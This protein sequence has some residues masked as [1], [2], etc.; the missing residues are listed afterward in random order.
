M[1]DV[2][3]MLQRLG[4]VEPILDAD[5][6]LQRAERRARRLSRTRMQRRLTAVGVAG[7]LLVG[8]VVVAARTGNASRVGPTT[9]LTNPPKTSIGVAPSKYVLRG[10]RTSDFLCPEHISGATATGQPVVGATALRVCV[11]GGTPVTVRAGQP[12]FEPL[13]AA[14][15]RPDTK[16]SHGCPLYADVPQILVAQTPVGDFRVS[17][18]V[19]GCGHYQAEV[20]NAVSAARGVLMMTPEQQ[21][22][23]TPSCPEDG[24]MLTPAQ[25]AMFATW[26]REYDPAAVAYATRDAGDASDLAIVTTMDF[27][28]ACRAATSALAAAEQASPTQRTAT[29]DGLMQPTLAALVQHAWPPKPAGS[30]LFN[31]LASLMRHGD[32]AR[33]SANLRVCAQVVPSP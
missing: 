13:L 24:P 28:A 2:R 9:S 25:K 5:E 22:Q 30:R 18:P 14:L 17:M 33:A 3:E 7:V 8:G 19:D 27:R 4:E 26:R 21:A 29:V 31:N 12:I 32:F 10:A 6:V 20:R 16:V 23:C 1:N 11:T 15:A